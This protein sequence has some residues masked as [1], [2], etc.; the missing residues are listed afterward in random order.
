MI[1][2][3]KNIQ[4]SM[5][6]HDPSSTVTVGRFG[7]DKRINEKVLLLNPPSRDDNNNNYNDNDKNR[8]MTVAAALIGP[9]VGWN[10][11]ADQSEA[12]FEQTYPKRRRRKK[13]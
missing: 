4:K 11:F 6:R 8:P 5:W 10:R 1:V 3:K 7:R 9:N 13:R 2:S 12:A